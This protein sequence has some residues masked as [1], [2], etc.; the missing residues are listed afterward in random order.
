MDGG[1]FDNSWK[2]DIMPTLFK[3]RSR[4]NGSYV[5][6]KETALVWHYRNSDPDFAFVRANELK[7]E[8]NE[9]LIHNKNLQILEGNK[10]VE[11]K[12]NGYDKGT[13][14]AQFMESEDYDFV[15][16][17]G[18]DSTDE[19]LFKAL[20]EESYS[21]KVGLVQSNAKYNLTHQY[22]VNELIDRLME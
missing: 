1:N 21:I 11:I 20:P 4:C 7:E 5:E 18:D 10:I 16:A 22:E 6:E 17:I 13:A 8:L 14:A 2:K 9:M 15:L 12:I 19:E 3:Y